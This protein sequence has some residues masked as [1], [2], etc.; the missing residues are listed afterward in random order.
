MRSCKLPCLFESQ[1]SM[2]TFLSHHIM[3]CLDQII[4]RENTEISV[5]SSNIDFFVYF[6][7]TYYEWWSRGLWILRTNM[8]CLYLTLDCRQII[9]PPLPCSIIFP[10]V[11]VV[12]TQTFTRT[13]RSASASWGPGLGAEA[14]FGHQSRTYCKFWF[15]YRVIFVVNKYTEFLL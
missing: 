9:Q 1:N 4:G 8:G 6:V 2:L 10:N 14:R 12:W 3:W 5:P 13:A 7:R 15:Q 11:R